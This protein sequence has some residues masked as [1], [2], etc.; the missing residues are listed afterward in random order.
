[1]E[2]KVMDQLSGLTT[3]GKTAPCR[4]GRA[5]SDPADHRDGLGRRIPF[6]QF[7]FKNVKKK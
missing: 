5:G 4:D 7:P 3:G 1:M 6:K 2:K